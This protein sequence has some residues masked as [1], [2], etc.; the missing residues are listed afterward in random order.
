MRLVVGKN[1]DVDRYGVPKKVRDAAKLKP[2]RGNSPESR[3]AQNWYD[4]SWGK[5]AKYAGDVYDHLDR[6]QAKLLAAQR[7]VDNG[8]KENQIGR[9]RAAQREFDKV[10]KQYRKLGTAADA[11]K[12][13]G[14]VGKR[15][16]KLLSAS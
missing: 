12:V 6:A 10:Y 7:A 8:G 5:K 11:F 15:V 4:Y 13:G 16:R 14:A 3:E 2:L 9:L 1:E